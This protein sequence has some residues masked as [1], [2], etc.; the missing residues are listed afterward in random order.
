MYPR[1]AAIGRIQDVYALKLLRSSRLFRKASLVHPKKLYA[2]GCPFHEFRIYC[3]QPDR[4]IAET[5]RAREHCFLEQCMVGRCVFPRQFS[6]Q[7]SSRASSLPPSE[8]AAWRAVARVLRS[9]LDAVSC[10]VFPS[11]CRL[12]NQPL[13][14]LS[15]APICADCWHDLPEQDPTNLCAVCGELLGWGGPRFASSSTEDGNSLC[16]LC[17]RAR[18]PFQLAVAYGV[19]EG[20]LRGLI[21]L[22]KYERI[23]TIAEPLGE[24]LATSIARSEDLPPTLTVVAVPLHA[25]KQ[26]E[27]GFNQ[28][29]LLAEATVRSLRRQRPDLD[30]HL[31][32]QAMGRQRATENQSGLTPRQRRRNLRGAFFI[33][34]PEQIAGRSI[35]LLD[36]IYTTGA[37]ARECTRT[38]LRAG[39]ASVHVATLARSQREGVAFWDF[40]PEATPWQTWTSVCQHGS[41]LGERKQMSMARATVYARKQKPQAKCHIAHSRARVAGAS[42]ACHGCADA[43]AGAGVERLL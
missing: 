15:N 21:H 17:E 5:L 32:L 3:T 28:T 35:L 6:R 29:I 13:L 34:Q 27:R 36:D 37:T 25:V 38:L 4:C 11:L 42:A 12:C 2:F 16:H 18:P 22:L 7:S 8:M 10:A 23:S 41:Q 14:H 43:H 40:L 31:A 9:P 19:Y 1:L 20:T 24:L 26:R 39:A 33:R 30:L